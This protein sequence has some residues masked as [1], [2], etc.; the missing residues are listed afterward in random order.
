[1]PVMSL[2]SVLLPLP[3]APTR[4]VELPGSRVSVTPSTARVA[5]RRLRSRYTFTR[6]VST[7]GLAAPRASGSPRDVGAAA[8][9]RWGRRRSGALTSVRPCLRAAMPGTRTTSARGSA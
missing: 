1:M 9:R 8:G 2:A 4:A 7:T 3:L 5:D 6:S